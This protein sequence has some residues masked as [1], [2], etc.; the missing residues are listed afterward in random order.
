MNGFMTNEELYTHAQRE[1][2]W[3]CE[4]P[5]EGLAAKFIEDLQH[6]ISILERD[7]EEAEQEKA[8][9]EYRV[10][11]LEQQNY[12]LEQELEAE[13]DRDDSDE[14]DELKSEVEFLR[15]LITDLEEEL[16]AI[17]N[18]QGGS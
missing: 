5:L 12:S 10:D 4:T 17:D 6:D 13:R 18:E 2:G 8:D 9:S 1:V 15:T 14:V 7:L 16:A 3:F 11:D